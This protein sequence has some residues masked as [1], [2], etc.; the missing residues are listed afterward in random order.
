MI[1]VVCPILNEEQYIEQCL[2]SLLL[3]EELQDEMEIIFVDGG[4]TDRTKELIRPYC[5][6]NPQIS[7]LD[8]PKRIQSAAMN[9]GIGAA[10]GNI[11]VRV[12]A[13]AQFPA[14]YVAQ[15]VHYLTIL[16]EAGNVGCGVDT[17]SKSR[18]PKALSIAKVMQDKF[19]VGNSIFRI[20]TDTKEEYIETDTVPFGCFQKELLQQ[21]GGFNEKLM[22]SEDNDINHR[23]KQTGKKIY[24]IT[25]LSLVY[26]QR[27]TFC[28]MMQNRY[29][30]GRRMIAESV[31]NH[32]LQS[33][34]LRHFVP[35][36][37]VGFLILTAFVGIFFLPSLWVCL[38]VLTFYLLC[39]LIR[40]VQINTKETSIGW[41]LWSFIT[42][43]FS[44]GFG[45]IIGILDI[46]NP[47]TYK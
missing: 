10:Q 7:L 17:Q 18:T 38:G 46:I 25:G 39:M 22:R 28:S 3:Q 16:P 4:S 26:Y 19:G 15:L 34:R 24:L 47:K 23:I 14:N 30:T 6:Q 37:F 9:I 33:L 2:K 44:T 20:G 41:L 8:N 12:D 43:H 40:S 45:S 35:M 29:I 1:S 36:L 27:D 5:E 13:H 11:I 32:T 21:I 42:L 31:I